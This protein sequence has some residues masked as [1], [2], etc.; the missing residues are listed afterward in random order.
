[1]RDILFRGMAVDS[2]KWVQGYYTNCHGAE[3][4]HNTTGHFIVEYPDKWHEI[5]T[6][7]IGQYTGLCDKNGKRIFEGDI[8]QR[9][10]KETFEIKWDR[11]GFCLSAKSSYTESGELFLPLIRIEE[12][13]VIGNVFENQELLEKFSYEK[14]RNDFLSECLNR[15]V[16]DDKRD[17]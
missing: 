4:E 17:N 3:L 2:K 10:E 8:V 5:Y 13:E 12:M 14:A 15:R 7:T 1:M 16:G 9:N 11:G 6:D